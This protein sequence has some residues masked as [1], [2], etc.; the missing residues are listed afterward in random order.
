MLKA[1]SEV[2][3]EEILRAFDLKERELSDFAP[4][5]ERLLRE[6]LAD[7]GIRVHSVDAGVKE[8]SSLARKV[9]AHQPAYAS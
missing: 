4:R 9:G 1:E 7:R 5:V 3:V 2:G 6:L 8:R